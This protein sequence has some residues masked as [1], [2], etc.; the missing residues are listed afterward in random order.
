MADLKVTLEMVIERMKK[1]RDLYEKSEE[2]V[3][4]QIVNPILKDLGWN[5]E[6]PEEVQPNI[7][8]EEGVP[9][10]LLLKNEKKVLFIEAKKL[11]VD[12]EEKE[13]IRKLGQYCFGEGMKYGVLSNGVIWILF[14]AFQEG[15]TMAER[16]VWKVDLENDDMTASIRKLTTISKDNIENIET[17]I[18]K[19]QILDEIWQSLLE[20]PKELIGGL[21]PVF[22]K[23]IK[24]GYPKYEFVS[25]EMEDFIKERVRELISPPT[26]TVIEET[27]QS[28]PFEERV[29]H[30]KMKIGKDVFEI[31]NSYEILITTANWLIKQG[32]LKLTD[33][34]V[35][36]GYKRNLINKEPKHKYGGDFRAP[37]KLSNGLW[38][39]VHYSTA[40]CI[41][42]ARRL[43]EK[44]GYS[45]NTLEVQ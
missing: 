6:N 34:P 15:T 29:R 9:D 16:L 24:E 36:I 7:S 21:I 42:T 19:L 4:Y 18:K 28:E 25:L 20:E 26:E 13:I 32:K 11:S 8:S 27:T 35:G 5:P 41:N 2:S 37:K 14:R 3:R 22:E 40:G 1:H 17:L 33:C 45:S 12:V 10:Y 39:D 23:L 44:F 30:G 43:L 38:I 31:R